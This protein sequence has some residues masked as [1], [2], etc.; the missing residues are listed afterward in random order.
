MVKKPQSSVKSQTNR[1]LKLYEVSEFPVNLKNR[2][3]Y[4]LKTE[5]FQIKNNEST[6]KR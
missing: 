6:Y 3:S 1:E 4:N 5:N 2:Q